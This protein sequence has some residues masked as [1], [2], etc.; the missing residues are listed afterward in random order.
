[1]TVLDYGKVIASGPPTQVQNDPRVIEAY[2][3]AEKVCIG[4]RPSVRENELSE[5]KE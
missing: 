1:L 4:T 5:A 2:L 3:G